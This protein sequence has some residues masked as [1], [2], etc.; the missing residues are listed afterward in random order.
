MNEL[1]AAMQIALA[2]TFAMYF[3]AHSNHWNVEGTD[4]AQY[5]GFLGDLYDELFDAVDP[6][7]E[8]IRALD[9][10]APVSLVDMMRYATVEEDNIKP[11]STQMIFSNLE[12]ANTAVIESLN[13]AFNLA[14][15]NNGLQNFLA[16]RLDKHAKHAWM[17]RSIQK[18][19]GA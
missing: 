2:N 12:S 15:G 16:D 9:A 18:N 4:F 1:Q 6:I 11:A 5:H 13:K 14:A 17:L 10:Y 19:F 7:A 3:K 8:Q